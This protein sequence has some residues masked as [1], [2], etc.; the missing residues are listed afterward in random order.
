V[1]ATAGSDETVLEVARRMAQHNV[2][3]L[4][5]VNEKSEPLAIVTDRDIVIRCVAPELDPRSTPVSVIMSRAVRSVDESTPIEQALRTMAS[6]GARR[7]VVTGAEGRLVG[8]LALDDVAQ[9]VAEE[10]EA[11][12]RLLGKEAPELGVGS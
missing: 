1:V 7:L 5:I 9:L 4:V 10:A 8:V 6:A 12:G 11:I 2:G 3:T